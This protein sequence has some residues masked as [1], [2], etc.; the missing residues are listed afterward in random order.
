MASA[1]AAHPDSNP[2]QPDLLLVTCVKK[3]L[4]VPAAAKDLYIS[5]LF[6]KQR[7]YA[8]GRGIP[9]F[10]LS[11]EHGLVAPDNW[12]AP[13]ERYLPDTPPTYRAAWGAW[14][15]ER[16]DLLAGPLLG[17]VVEIHAG[18]PYIN[19]I[20]DHLT[21]KG[22][23]VVNRLEGL[24]MGARLQWY[25]SNGT[26]EPDAEGVLENERAHAATSSFVT[27]LLDESQ[28]VAPT[29]FLGH[30]GEGLRFHGLYSWWVDDSGASDLTSGLDTQV[31][32]GLIYAG[33][34][35]ATRWP[36]GKRSSNTL[37][38]RISGMHLGGRHEFSTFRKTLGSILANTTGSS[39]ID[40]EA[41]T[42]WMKQHLKVLAVP[43]H[44][45][46][47]LGKLEDDVLRKIDPPLNLQGMSPSPIRKRLKELRRNNR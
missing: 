18:A 22:A 13:Y 47:T 41:L 8:E 11:A 25:T 38:S 3:K 4:A 14:A 45:A 20:A 43:H 2:E 44:D 40:E 9:W 5:S 6:K 24:T 12:L 29:E 10:I 30:D 23:T 31:S 28:A 32:R 34:A 17:K 39:T 33:L 42:I 37:W 19:A 1:P 46:D 15:V 7:T 21:A 26:V 35:G 27:M 16:L 36:S